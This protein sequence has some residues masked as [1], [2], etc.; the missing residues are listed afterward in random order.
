MLLDETR[1]T[2]RRVE[3]AVV[4]AVG[5]PFGAEPTVA[6]AIRIA[7]RAN[8]VHWLWSFAADPNARVAA[9]LS[10]EVIGIARET[11][12]WG[13]ERSL[14]G[15]YRAAQE[16]MWQEWLVASFD[17]TQDVR[18]LEPVLRR[19]AEC[20]GQFVTDTVNALLA[21]LDG[22]R[23]SL[24]RD[25]H[26]RRLDLVSRILS[27]A[28]VE[29]EIA[30]S[31]L[32]Y[33]VDGPHIGVIAWTDARSADR[34]ELRRCMDALAHAAGSPDR[35]VLDASTSSSWLWLGSARS[36]SIADAERVTARHS[37]V[38]IA[39]GPADVGVDGFRRTHD[40][41]AETQRLMYEATTR[42]VVS[43]NDVALVLVTTADRAGFHEFRERVLGGLLFAAPELRETLRVYIREQYNASAAARVLFTHRNT[44][45]GRVQRAEQL[46]P[47]PLAEQGLSVGL[48]LEVTYWL[49]EP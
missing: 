47:A 24:Y 26:V 20:L 27:G 4:D 17:A 14:P 11:L 5:E 39:L 36:L 31:E 49:D 7:T 18:L 12:R 48:A 25:I 29:S 33:P 42:R 28:S 16:V 21:L 2:L 30:S 8:A 41:A 40:R 1:G 34:A 44:V 23:L 22:E 13:V 15:G 6:E 32:H 45:L 43:Y 46:L 3:D 19:A 10:P 35:L 37:S 38:R 9:N